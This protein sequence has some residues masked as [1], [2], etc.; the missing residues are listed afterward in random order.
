MRELL[1]GIVRPAFRHTPALRRAGLTAIDV[2]LAPVLFF[3]TLRHSVAP[4]VAPDKSDADVDT[5]N[6]AAED[7]FAK[8]GPDRHLLRKP[9]SEPESLSR[10]LIDVGVLIDGMRLTPGMTVLELGAGS[11]WVSH[12]LN[13]MGCRTIAVDVSPSALLL[14][15]ALFEHDT[16]T[17]WTLQP[18]FLSYDGR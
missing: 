5:F 10:R 18:L 7:Y 2:L 16:D 3:F 9:F 14:G 15:R 8:L 6:R 11:C 17:N 13:R 4:A 1:R 12:F